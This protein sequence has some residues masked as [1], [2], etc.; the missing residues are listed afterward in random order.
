MN[1]GLSEFDHKKA[2]ITASDLNLAAIPRNS[3]L[4]FTILQPAVFEVE[5]MEGK[6]FEKRFTFGDSFKKDKIVQDYQV[7]KNEI[8]GELILQR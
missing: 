3:L 8:I 4:T 5:N 2:K 6:H 7:P 1:F